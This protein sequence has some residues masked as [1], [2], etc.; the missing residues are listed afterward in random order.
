MD[1]TTGYGEGLLQ[2]VGQPF[3]HDL[4]RIGG[5]AL[6][7]Q[8]DELVAAEAGEHVIGVEEMADALVKARSN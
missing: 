4:G 3:G 7:D 8:D 6:H 2:R 5:E 1:L